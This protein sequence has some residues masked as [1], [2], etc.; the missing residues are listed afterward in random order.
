MKTII[1]S[2]DTINS[3]CGKQTPKTG[4]QYRYSTY[5]V[6]VPCEDGTLLYHTLTGELLLLSSALEEADREW[7][8]EHWFLVPEGFDEKAKTD[9]LRVI[10][11]ML[12]KKSTRKTGFTILTTTDC[13][14]RCFYCYE[15]GLKRIPM[16]PE[17]AVKVA[18]YIVSVCGGKKVRIQWFGGEPL[19]NRKVIDIICDRLRDC[20]I[21]YESDMTSNGFYLDRDTSLHARDKWNLS[22]IQ[23]TVDGTESVYNRTKA[24]IDEDENPYLRIMENIRCALETGI[25]VTVRMNLGEHNAKDLLTLADELAERF[26]CYEGFQAYVAT[27]RDFSGKMPIQTT[28][29]IMKENYDRIC[30]RLVKHGFLRRR[31]LPSEIQTSRCMADSDSHEV[32]LPD[33][34]VGRCEHC[35]DSMITGSI[36]DNVRDKAV[37][38]AW[39]EPLQVQEC[40]RCAV[41]PICKK[42]K[43]CEWNKDGCLELDRMIAIDVLKDQIVK[44]YKDHKAEE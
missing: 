21:Q 36:Q 6:T 41:Y 13:N 35:S 22:K 30:D 25:K 20:G 44:A 40:A 16:T 3:I 37:E 5:C 18:N 24:Y 31:K 42:L 32:I 38:K 17:T 26:H 12:K 27:I 10:A 4:E 7:M 43:M 1:P 19:Y 14:A 11:G 33:G 15:I 2:I 34:R 28:T 23:I 39:K 29:L 9:Q 8:I